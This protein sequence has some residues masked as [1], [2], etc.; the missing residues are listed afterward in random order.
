MDDGKLPGYV[1]VN[2]QTSIPPGYTRVL[3]T[4]LF[5]GGIGPSTRPRDLI[6]LF[7][8]FGPMIRNPIVLVK[9]ENVPGVTPHNAI[10]FI[11]FT[12]RKSCMQAIYRL[13]DTRW[14]GRMINV[15]YGKPS[16]VHPNQ[17]NFQ[18]GEMVLQSKFVPKDVLRHNGKGMTALT[19]W[20]LHGGQIE[21]VP[22]LCAAFMESSCHFGEKCNNIHDVGRREEVQDAIKRKRGRFVCWFDLTTSCRAGNS[23]TRIHLKPDVHIRRRSRSPRNKHRSPSPRRSTKRDSIS[24]LSVSR[25]KRP[26]VMPRPNDEVVTLN[27]KTLRIISDIHDGHPASGP[28]S[29]PSSGLPSG[30]PSG[31][32]SG[33]AGSSGPSVGGTPG[34][35]TYVIT[36][37]DPKEARPPPGPLSE[38]YE[39][40]SP[41]PPF[42]AGRRPVEGRKS[43]SLPE[44]TRESVGMD[45]F[46]AHEESSSR[47]NTNSE[48]ISKKPKRSQRSPD[49]LGSFSPH[50]A[51]SQTIFPQNS[52]AGSR[53]SG[54]LSSG[55]RRGKI[56]SQN[57]NFNDFSRSSLNTSEVANHKAGT[58]SSKGVR[59]KYGR[60]SGELSRHKTIIKQEPSIGR[61]PAKKRSS[62]QSSRDKT[63]KKSKSSSS[64][65][66]WNDRK[67]SYIGAK[68][69]SPKKKRSG[70]SKKSPKKKDSKK[71][72]GK[73]YLASPGKS[74]KK[75]TSRSSSRRKQHFLS[76]SPSVKS[77]SQSS[78]GISDEFVSIGPENL[79]RQSYET[80][81]PMGPEN[82]RHVDRRSYEAGKPIGPE[83][84]RRQSYE[85]DKP[86]G[87]E[88]LGNEK[89]DDRMRLGPNPMSDQAGSCYST[90]RNFPH[91]SSIT[92][93]RSADQL[94]SP[95]DRAYARR[96]D[97]VAPRQSTNIS[98]LPL[99]GTSDSR[100][101]QEISYV[102]PT[103]LPPMDSRSAQIHNSENIQAQNGFSV[104]QTTFS[105]Q[106]N[107]P[108]S[109]QN[110]Q[111]ASFSSQQG[112]PNRMQNIQE[113]TFSSQQG[114][115]NRMQN[116]QEA[117]FSSLQGPPNSAQTIQETSFSTQQGPSNSTQTII[118]N[119]SAISLQS[120]NSEREELFNQ[121]KTFG[122]EFGQH[123]LTNLNNVL[124]TW[125]LHH[126]VNHPQIVSY[127]HQLSAQI[128]EARRKLEIVDGAV[129]GLRDILVNSPGAPRPVQ[130]DDTQLV[131]TQAPVSIRPTGKRIKLP[132]DSTNNNRPRPVPTAQIG[133]G[134]QSVQSGGRV[135]TQSATTHS[136][137]SVN[138]ARYPATNPAKEI[139]CEVDSIVDSRHNPESNDLEYLLRWVSGQSGTD[140]SDEWVS[141]A[142][143]LNC[144]DLVNDFKSRQIVR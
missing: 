97:L 51:G 96:Q 87:P 137:R 29:G 119:S 130:R 12:W 26:R 116:I 16:N 22:M 118:Q 83:N 46:R 67:P 38:K 108:N 58:K 126:Q 34:S 88:N 142:N 65:N 44:K 27:G 115:P 25:A 122:T 48:R 61:S 57:T 45:R 69:K 75:S 120:V 18:T 101:G 113:A 123:T 94:S 47:E 3:S 138:H 5:V 36:G 53:F 71:T 92:E 103:V 24:N 50:I 143:L 39:R 79:R 56:R 30:P 32:S 112:L 144:E 2:Y 125:Q 59:E 64:K 133:L 93:P 13:H 107:R 91:S 62:R 42:S 6:E 35:P 102:A 31:Q 114:L 60:N 111:E 124:A 134:S 73:T 40:K 86:M 28:P 17:V 109:T 19:S 1:L 128:S 15:R 37:L 121:L 135:H 72:A 14:N 54:R 117:T 41:S 136:A 68:K 52:E 33:S 80:D 11:H 76:D 85:T 90:G 131:G 7:D 132:T 82:F 9:S 81:K 78:V 105:S 23:C 106:Q 99:P 89:Y 127:I 21:M 141:A 49:R 20:A 98:Q 8:E 55:D 84:L 104:A 95:I 139:E 74:H 100:S 66:E 4:I 63:A 70:G 110:V 10:A 129:S 77:R 43:P 140:F